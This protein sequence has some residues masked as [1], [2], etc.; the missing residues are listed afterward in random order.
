MELRRK[1]SVSPHLKRV[2]EIAS[3][4]ASKIRGDLRKTRIDTPE[5][6]VVTYWFASAAKSFD[7]AMLLWNCGYWQNAAMTGRS[8]LEVALQARFFLKDPAL[9]AQHFFAHAEK[10]KLDLFGRFAEFAEPAMKQE[11]EDYFT[12][13]GVNKTKIQKWKNW[14]GQ[15]DSIWDLVAEIK[16][17]NAYRSQYGPLSFLVHTTPAAFLWY[18]QVDDGQLAKIDWKG[19]PP[20]TK[21]YPMA[22]TMLTSAPTGLLDVMAV[23]VQI[24]GF[25]HDADFEAARSALEAYNNE[26]P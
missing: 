3:A 18:I 25:E 6:R 5:K 20:S 14:W 8:I 22:E 16:A 24:F 21:A 11:I 23:L 7:A 26:D 4:L 13:L 15:A 1:L 12:Q 10:Q 2:C 17:Q 9:Y 19:G